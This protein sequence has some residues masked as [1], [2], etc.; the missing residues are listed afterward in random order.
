MARGQ[1]RTTPP[2]GAA[3]AAPLT[4]RRIIMP[5]PANENRRKGDRVSTVVA[6]GALLTL[7]ALALWASFG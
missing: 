1:R 6:L 5:R 4:P 2:K 3:R 7:A